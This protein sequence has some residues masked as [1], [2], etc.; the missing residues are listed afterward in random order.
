MLASKVAVMSFFF[1][2]RRRHT[3]CSRDWSSDVCSSDLVTERR[4]IK[5]WWTLRDSNPE[6]LLEQQVVCWSGFAAKLL[7]RECLVDVRGFEPLTP[8]LQSRCSPS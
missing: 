5:F 7:K 6:P 2:S 3:R 8:C 1:S 4:G